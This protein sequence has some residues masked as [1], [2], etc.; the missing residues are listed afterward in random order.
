MRLLKTSLGHDRQL[1]WIEAWDE[2]I[3][4]YAILSHTWSIVSSD[5]V[6]FRDI[7]D[8]TAS[9]RPAYAKV[10]GAMNL[11]RTEGHQYIWIDTLCIDKTS[12]AE[13][14]EAINSMYTYYSKAGVCYVYMSDVTAAE[15]LPAARW[16]TRG[17]TLQELLAPTH[18][19]F[20]NSDWQIIGARVDLVDKISSITRIQQQYLVDGSREVVWT[21]SIAKRMSWAATRQTGRSEDMAYSLLGLFA[22]NMPL[23]YG[24]GGKRAFLRLQE[25]IM[26]STDD[27]TIFAWLDYLGSD[28]PHGLLADDPWAFKRTGH[29]QPYTDHGNRRPYA[30]T[31]RGLQINLFLTESKDGELLAAL[32]CPPDPGK[33]RGNLAIVLKRWPGAEEGADFQRYSRIRCS[34]LMVAGIRGE[35]QNLYVPQAI[36]QVS[37][38]GMAPDMS[39]L[40]GRPPAPYRLR[41]IRYHDRVRNPNPE[42]DRFTDMPVGRGLVSPLPM[43]LEPNTVSAVLLL[44]SNTSNAIFAVLL[45][46]SASS[47]AAFDVKLYRHPVTYFTIPE[48]MLISKF[49]PVESGTWVII[50]SCRFKI[51]FEERFMYGHQVYY[52]HLVAVS[53]RG[54]NETEVLPHSVT[55]PALFKQRSL[56]MRIARTFWYSD[57]G[58]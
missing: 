26:K 1:E 24:E 21:A 23:L 40:M 56:P 42:G 16:W 57:R 12:S 19:V 15:S 14:S 51:G 53:D 13:L 8:G 6:T 3:P 47:E 37:G 9:K 39:F 7:L 17:W 55:G 25:E 2:G 33:P 18:V 32:D 49:E 46:S 31:N 52:V 4:P 22:V 29:Y 30:M 38:V 50:G 28:T 41:S 34:E 20:Y 58:A 54:R 10:T 27:H 11:A 48:A 43:S 44:E 5:E 35:A 36:A 45:G